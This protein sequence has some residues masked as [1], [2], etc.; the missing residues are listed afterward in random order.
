V[1]IDNRKAVF[2]LTEYLIKNNKRHMSFINGHKE[3]FMAMERFR[4]FENALKQYGIKLNNNI[5][6]HGNFSMESGYKLAKSILCENNEIDSVFAASDNIAIDIISFL[7]DYNQNL[8]EKTKI[9]GFDDI[10]VAKVIDPLLTTV[11]IP[12]AKSGKIGTDL[13]LKLINNKKII[14]KKIILEHKLIYKIIGT[15]DIVR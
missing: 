1:I 11:R 12:K 14:N 13:L 6:R 9:I 10:E 2:E 3:S 8:L 15:I 5:I 4:G 7:K